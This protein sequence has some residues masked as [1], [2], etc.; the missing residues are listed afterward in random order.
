MESNT[1]DPDPK[2]CFHLHVVVDFADRDMG[3]LTKGS[4][5]R[6]HKPSIPGPTVAALGERRNSNLISGPSQAFF[7]LLT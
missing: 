7:E 2:N 4:P 5:I 6:I 3:P 1:P